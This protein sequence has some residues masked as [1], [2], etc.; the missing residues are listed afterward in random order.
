[1]DSIFTKIINKEIPAYIIEENENF[2]AF[3]D[4]FPLAKGHTLVIPKKQVDYIFDL[5]KDIY[6]GL[7]TFVQKVAEKVEKA[8]DCERIGIAVI[9]LEVPH[10]HIHLVPINN[11]E[12]INFSKPKLKLEEDEFLAI[13]KSVLNG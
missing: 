10:A 6:S 1:M 8:I 9:G 2:I 13:H 5:D 3:L 7:W 12:D 11:I 4:V